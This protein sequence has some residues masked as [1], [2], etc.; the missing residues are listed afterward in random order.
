M[1]KRWESRLLLWT[2]QVSTIWMVVGLVLKY[3]NWDL[4]ESI[5]TAFSVF[6]LPSYPSLFIAILMVLLT[7]GL[8]RGNRGALVFYLLGFQ[9]PSL[10]IGIAYL[11]IVVF[12]AEET[13]DVFSLLVLISTAASVLFLVAGWRARDEFP[14][15][16]EGSW[17]KALVVL[18]GR[19]CGVV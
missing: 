2:A 5:A 14:A 8:L 19:H 13:L 17:V 3:I 11:L 10:L 9:V 1:H 4:T 16:V 15:R 6:N 12:D 18:G 7:S